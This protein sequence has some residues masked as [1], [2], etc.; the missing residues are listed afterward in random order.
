M[1]SA[2]GQAR[3]AAHLRARKAALETWSRRI[4]PQRFDR[5]W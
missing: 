2:E 5:G 4:R 1:M 3:H